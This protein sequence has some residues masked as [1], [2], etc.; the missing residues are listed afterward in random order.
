MA[1]WSGVLCAELLAENTTSRRVEDWLQSLLQCCRYSSVRISVRNFIKPSRDSEHRTLRICRSATKHTLK[2]SRQIKQREDCNVAGVQ[3]KQNVCQNSEHSS[4]RRVLS[5]VHRLTT[6]HQVIL[7]KVCQK[8]LGVWDN[9]APTILTVLTSLRSAD[10]ILDQPNPRLLFWESAWC[11]LTSSST[12]QFRAPGKSRQ[13]NGARSPKWAFN[14]YV[15]RGSDEH[16][17]PGRAWTYLITSPSAS[18]VE[19]KSQLTADRRQGELWS[20][21]ISNGVWNIGDFVVEEAVQD[22]S[23]SASIGAW[24]RPSSCS[25]DCHRRRGCQWRSVLLWDPG[26]YKNP[27]G[28]LD[29]PLRTQQMPYLQPNN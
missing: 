22:A 29:A 16:C 14:S 5:F 11:R 9:V 4:L 13:R 27:K 10:K 20:R 24:P 7:L 26:R 28:A 25:K 6:W 21:R 12:G 2:S 23:M 17:L 15:G 19:T 1:F 18:Q 3:R 8:L